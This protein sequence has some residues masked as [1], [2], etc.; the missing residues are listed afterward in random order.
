[1]GS[2]TKAAYADT[3]DHVDACDAELGSRAEVADWSALKVL[4]EQ[5]ATIIADGLAIPTTFNEKNYFVTKGGNKYYSS[6]RAFFFERHD[7]SPPSNWLIHDTLGDLTLGSWYG[8]TGQVL[9]VIPEPPRFALGFS[10]TKA[11]YADTDDH[12]DACDAEL[13]SRAEGADWVA[14]KALGEQ[15]ATIIADGLAIPTT[16]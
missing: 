7:G 15:A 2:L 5:A 12:A 6:N 1:M 9:C 14:L 16:F 3:D 10:L 13:G 4:G 11:A 8:I